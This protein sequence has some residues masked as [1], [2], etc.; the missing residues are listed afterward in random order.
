MA[1]RA[2]GR[3]PPSAMSA[4]VPGG[5][6]GVEVGGAAGGETFLPVGADEGFEV[7]GAEGGAVEAGAVEVLAEA[8]TGVDVAEGAQG[9]E[10]FGG[11]TA[12]AEVFRGGFE[13]AQEAGEEDLVV[14]GGAGA[15]AD[16]EGAGDQFG[17]E[18]GPVVGLDAAHGEA[19]DGCEARGAEVFGD[20]AVL[21]AD[22]VGDR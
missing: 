1:A 18:R 10:G 13:G 20:E 4:S 9:G 11:E 8:P 3:S 15:A 12:V 2:W 7:G 19:V 21:G 14:G 22:V 6:L 17:V 16:D 5:G